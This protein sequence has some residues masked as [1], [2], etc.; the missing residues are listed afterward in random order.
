MKVNLQD[1]AWPIVLLVMGSFPRPR[2]FVI[3]GGYAAAE[4]AVYLTRYG[5]SVTMIIREPD[6]TCAKLTAEAAK[7]TR[8]LRL[9]ITQKKEITGDDFVRKAVFVNNQT[10]EETVYEAPKDSTFGLF[11]LLK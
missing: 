1:A 9:F 7:I 3:G 10:G 2:Y 4:E 8:K 6:F 5:K 11:V